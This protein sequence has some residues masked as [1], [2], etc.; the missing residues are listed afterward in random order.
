MI[1]E[2]LYAII[3]ISALVGACVWLVRAGDDLIDWLGSPAF[4][5]RINGEVNSNIVFQQQINGEVSPAI[6]ISH[7]M[8]NAPK[9]GWYLV[10]EP[11]KKIVKAAKVEMSPEE[12]YKDISKLID[13]KLEHLAKSFGYRDLYEMEECIEMQH[14]RTSRYRAG[15]R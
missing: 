7:L 11:K 12:R 10:E 6:D 15:R 8:E 9:P 5:Q 2:A 1:G 13:I 14:L 4:Q 3:L